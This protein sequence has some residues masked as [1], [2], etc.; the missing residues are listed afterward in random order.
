MMF[1][2][3]K[4]NR[5]HISTIDGKVAYDEEFH[6]GVNI[7]RGE[8][9]SGKSTISHF[10]FYVLGGAFSNWVKEAKKCNLVKA[11][12]E[13]NKQVITI[14]RMVEDHTKAPIYFHFGTFKNSL[15]ENAEWKKYGYDKTSERKSFSNVL[16]NE[17][18]FPLVYGDSNITMHQILRLL[19]VDQDS[20]TNSLFLYEQFDSQ[21]TRETVSD[22]LLGI[23][24][25][26]LYLNK[27]QLRKDKSKL[28]E[29][30]GS[31]KG[32][33]RVI[34]SPQ[35]LD[36]ISLNTKIDNTEMQ[37][38]KISEDIILL[39]EEKKRVNYSKKSKLEYQVLKDKAIK[40]REALLT[41]EEK[42]KQIAYESEDTLNFIE[43]LK[44]KLNAI[45][46]SIRTREYLGEFQL[47]QCPECLK[48]LIAE[49]TTNHCKLCKTEIDSSKGLNQARKIEQEIEFQIKESEKILN[50]REQQRIN[51][52]I[53]I[54]SHTANHNQL[55][56]EVNNSLK[57]IK[58]FR[59]EK[60]D[61]LY[62]DKGFKE[63]EL[64][65]FRTM[66]EN[67]E[68]Y[69]VLIKDKQELERNIEVR[70][71]TITKSEAKQ[72]RLKRKVNKS[73]KEEGLNFLKNDLY[74]QKEFKNATKFNIDFRNNLAFLNDKDLR[75]SASSDFYL[76]TTARFALFFTSLKI[77]GLRY[78]RFI[79]CDNME[80]K[81]IEAIRAENFQKIIIDK[82]KEYDEDD[83]QI[84]YTT[85]FITK[86]LNNSKY[87]VGDYYNESNPS[88]KNV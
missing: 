80:D 4:L 58:S 11:E 32:I 50:F 18:D 3:L 88:L 9:S 21:L 73:I 41:L 13:V 68:A 24:N 64:L 6:S 60:I 70:T 72:E 49:N 30:K 61:S 84:I 51:L 59:S 66:L 62:T 63:G 36:P 35:N 34:D 71:D 48:P 22:L 38:Q 33:K 69:Q 39:K 44:L 10:I 20:P 52:V 29:I 79:L 42:E 7:I 14:K 16:F 40:S 25:E 15:K 53:K 23:Y 65:Q 85:S 82:S 26:E 81:G 55:Q 5:L 1:S 57:D 2:Q 17:L 43:S 74:R 54:D 76:K 8:N 83:F 27:I 77:N 47:E 56:K 37:L 28:D 86:E 87:V 45:R 12:I 46:N 31:I 75:F 78:P 19:Y 67:A